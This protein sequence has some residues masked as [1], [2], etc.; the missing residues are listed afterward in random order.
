MKTFANFLTVLLISIVG[1][2][3]DQSNGIV[4]FGSQYNLL[5]TQSQ[6]SLTDDSLLVMIA[7]SGCNGNHTFSLNYRISSST[8]EV[9]L[10]KETPD[11]A[12]DAYFQESRAFPVP[13]QVR[14]FSKVVLLGPPDKKFAL[15]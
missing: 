9:W 5:Q 1:C 4:Q 12:C 13:N 7:Y 2:V 6:P 3:N 15:K 11:Q 14:N 8:A 10:F